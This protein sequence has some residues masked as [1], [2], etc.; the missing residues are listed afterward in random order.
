M[1]NDSGLV[2]TGKVMTQIPVFTRNLR[3]MK[4]TTMTKERMRRPLTREKE[5][6]KVREKGTE[7]MERRYV[8]Q[9]LSAQLLYN[10]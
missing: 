6:R 9:F 8:C 7:V 5:K 2:R 1:Y 4:L 10:V 3:K